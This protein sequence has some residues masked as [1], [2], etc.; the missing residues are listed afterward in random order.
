MLIWQ[1]PIPF[2]GAR[3]IIERLW[4]PHLWLPSRLGIYMYISPLPFPEGKR[5]LCK[6]LTFLCTY[7][8]TR[9]EY[10]RALQYN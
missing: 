5:E 4:Y 10:S 6:G 1:I 2:K 8:T 9:C 7:L 3:E